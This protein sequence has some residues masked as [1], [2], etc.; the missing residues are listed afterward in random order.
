MEEEKD[1][2]EEDFENQSERLER[3]GATIKEEVEESLKSQTSHKS[4]ESLKSD[5][6]KKRRQWNTIKQH[7]ENQQP[8]YDVT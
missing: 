5:G 1:E 2:Y 3:S 4:K 6:S 8:V 7:S